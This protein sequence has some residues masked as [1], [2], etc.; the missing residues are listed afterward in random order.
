VSR[1][2]ELRRVIFQQVWLLFLYIWSSQ[3]LAANPAQLKFDHSQFMDWTQQL[4]PQQLRF[5][6]RQTDLYIQY[7]KNRIPIL[8]EYILGSKASI[9]KALIE[10]TVVSYRS[11]QGELIGLLPPNLEKSSCENYFRIDQK[12]HALLL[13]KLPIALDS[14]DPQIRVIARAQ[15][16][17]LLLEIKRHYAL[18]VSQSEGGVGLINKTAYSCFCDKR[19]EISLIMAGR[20]TVLAS[21]EILLLGIRGVWNVLPRTTQ[22]A[23]I[24]SDELRSM[25][26]DVYKITALTVVSIVGW[27]FASAGLSQLVEAGYL[28]TRIAQLTKWGSLM[29][30]IV[31][32]FQDYDL[33]DRFSE[34]E[35]TEE[36]VEK[37]ANSWYEQ[38]EELDNFIDNLPE[39]PSVLYSMMYEYEMTIHKVMVK[40]NPRK[41]LDPIVQKLIKRWGG[42]KP[43]LHLLSERQAILAERIQQMATPAQCL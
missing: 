21:L 6:Q 19:K 31:Y 23:E 4:G 13:R 27:E 3:T 15:I 22:L 17:F 41:T 24:F 43:A 35:W 26:N 32:Q 11:L 8:N 30:Y 2:A 25:R 42:K 12:L 7:L 36:M 37:P 28:S 38:L 40:K 29:A 39:Q 33:I 5:S 1:A 34:I 20:S 14:K 16:E 18:F 9:D 10:E